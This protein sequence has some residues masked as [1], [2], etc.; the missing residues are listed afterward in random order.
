MSLG[1]LPAS[2]LRTPASGLRTPASGAWPSRVQ[3]VASS[4]RKETVRCQSPSPSWTSR[5]KKKRA[6]RKER[7]NERKKERKKRKKERKKERRREKKKKEKKR[8]EYVVD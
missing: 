2:G 7:M 3:P 5:T 1:S 8:A 6:E 4:L